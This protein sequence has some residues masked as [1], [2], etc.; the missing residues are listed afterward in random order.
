MRVPPLLLSV[1]LLT[2]AVTGGGSN[3][4]EAALLPGN[5]LARGCGDQPAQR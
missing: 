4:E 2:L 5:S 1:T 3:P